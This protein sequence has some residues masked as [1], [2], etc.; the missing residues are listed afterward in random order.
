VRRYVLGVTCGV[1]GLALPLWGMNFPC[2]T[3][4]IFRKCLVIGYLP[5]SYQGFG[6]QA[7]T[8][9]IVSLSVGEI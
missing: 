7:V 2:V 6:L 5:G 8:Y 9:V 3:V 4:L 1:R